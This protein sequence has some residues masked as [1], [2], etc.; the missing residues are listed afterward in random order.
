[1]TDNYQTA[2]WKSSL[3][4]ARKKPNIVRKMTAFAVTTRPQAPPEIMRSYITGSVVFVM[5]VFEGALVSTIGSANAE[6]TIPVVRNHASS[7][8]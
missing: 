4:N 7:L 3:S 2:Y 8:H 6:T 1:M 5:G